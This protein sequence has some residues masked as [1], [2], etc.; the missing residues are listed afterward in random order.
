MDSRSLKDVRLLHFYCNGLVIV[1]A[2]GVFAAVGGRCWILDM[3][4][5]AG[6]VATVQ[7][8]CQRMLLDPFVYATWLDFEASDYSWLP[9]NL[10]CHGA[11]W[12]DV[13]GSYLVVVCWTAA[14]ICWRLHDA[15]CRH[16]RCH[17]VEASWFGSAE[18]VSIEDADDSVF[19]LVVREAGRGI[20]V[21]E[22]DVGWFVYA[23]ALDRFITFHQELWTFVLTM[24]C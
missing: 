1:A 8:G 17:F 4:S 14:G 22:F 6:D 21:V 11:S 10:I 19:E 7:P 13:I 3:D 2:G 23:D 24:F 15:V 20:D 5:T 16:F 12:C 9:G 18:V